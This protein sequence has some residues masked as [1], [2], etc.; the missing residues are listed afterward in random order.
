MNQSSLTDRLAAQPGPLLV[1]V[2]APWCA[3]CRAMAPALE[4]AASEF[5]DRVPLW[6][7]NADQDRA[8]VQE[9]KIMG[10]PTIVVY[11]DGVEIARRTGRMDYQELTA[12]FAW[13]ESDVTAAP[14]AGMSSQT[15]MLRLLVGV[16]ILVLA[17]FVGWPWPLLLVAGAVLFS[18]VHDRCPLWQSV[19]RMIL[20]AVQRPAQQA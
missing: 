6:R 8:S 1:E 18:A 11:R 10:V 13:A 17:G 7:I 12:L 2:W 4:K 5:A 9:L 20:P 14:P 15:R 16:G 19:K 3:P